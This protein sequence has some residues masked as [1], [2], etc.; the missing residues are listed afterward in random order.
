MGKTHIPNPEK[1]PDVPFSG[2][3]V[4]GN[5]CYCSG[6]LGLDVT[7]ME[8]AEGIEEQTVRAI[9]NINDTLSRAGF[10]MDDI[11]TATIYLKNLDDFKVMNGVYAR[12]FPGNKPSRTTVGVADLLMGALVEI[13]CLAEK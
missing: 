13:T 9:E 7:T 2:A 4:S 3:V 8:M 11:V 5:T 6:S 1:F 12:Y 10:E